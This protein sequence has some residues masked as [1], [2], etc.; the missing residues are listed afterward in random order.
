MFYKQMDFPAAAVTDD[1]IACSTFPMPT[2][3]GVMLEGSIRLLPYQIRRAES[4]KEAL[5]T[6]FCV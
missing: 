5:W 2:L 1:C 4:A 3:K 6:R